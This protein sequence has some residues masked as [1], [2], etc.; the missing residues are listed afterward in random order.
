MQDVTDSRGMEWKYKDENCRL[1]SNLPTLIET[2]F[3]LHSTKKNKNSSLI[4]VIHTLAS[5]PAS[6]WYSLQFAACSLKL[7][8]SAAISE[9]EQ[10]F[11]EVIFLPTIP[12][13]YWRF[14]SMFKHHCVT[15]RYT[16]VK[17]HTLYVHVKK[18]LHVTLR[19]WTLPPPLHYSRVYLFKHSLQITFLCSFHSRHSCLSLCTYNASSTLMWCTCAARCPAHFRYNTCAIIL[20]YT[21]QNVNVCRQN[22]LQ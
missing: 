14:I 17:I 2:V 18:C 11:V 15:W 3:Y 19:S 9:R 10:Q 20:S 12:V 7:V 8:C 5:R 1:C 13:P 22:S 4:D 6:L 21:S 16:V